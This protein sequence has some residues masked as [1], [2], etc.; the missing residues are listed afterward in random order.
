MYALRLP[1]D[2]IQ[3]PLSACF[4][5]VEVSGTGQAQQEEDRSYRQGH[6]E[7]SLD[8]LHHRHHYIIHT[9]STSA[10]FTSPT[11]SL[12]PRR[13]VTQRSAV[14]T[15]P[16]L[17]ICLESIH[18]LLDLRP[19]IC[20]IERRLM[21]LLSTVLTVPP[22]PIHTPLWPLLLQH[23]THRILVPDRIMRRVRW[24]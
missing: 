8:V 6:V 5:R 21:H 18:R 1:A 3:G 24:E 12:R 22:Q 9:Y 7:R 15:R 2:N 23:H 10:Y 11:S 20:T 19:Q 16:G 4:G 14:L 17:C 13:G